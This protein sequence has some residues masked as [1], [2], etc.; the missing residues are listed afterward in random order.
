MPTSSSGQTGTHSTNRPR[1][2][3]RSRSRLCPPSKR[4]SSPSRQREIP[5]R[6]RS[7][8]GHDPGRTTRSDQLSDRPEIEVEILGLQTELR[9]D[10]AQRLLELHERTA[11]VLHFLVSQR[12]RFHAA[13]RLSLE[14]LSDELHEREHELRH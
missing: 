8:M 10:V 6:G 13:D 12:S 2:E 4:T 9:R 11:D 7:L 3:M 5:T 14:Q 1:V